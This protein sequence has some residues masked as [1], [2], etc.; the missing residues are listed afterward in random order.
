MKVGEKGKWK[1]YL[2]AILAVLCLFGGNKV[3][4][5]AATSTEECFGIVVLFDSEGEALDASTAVV[6][7]VN[8]T[9][10]V[11][12]K[13]MDS[14]IEG[15]V[16]ILS[17]GTGNTYLLE[18]GGTDSLGDQ[19]LAL[20]GLDASGEGYENAGS[21]AA[22]LEVANP[23]QNEIAVAVYLGSESGE[24]EALA[25][26]LLECDENGILTTDQYPVDA[27]YPAA[28]VNDEGK[29]VGMC[30][31]ENKILAVGGGEEF[32]ANASEE[33]SPT[34]E[35]PSPTPE[36]PSPTP[37]EPSP[38]PEEP[39]PAP[40]A[41]PLPTRESRSSSETGET[42]FVDPVPPI[43]PD[44]HGIN[45]T[46]AVVAAV[47]AVIAVAVVLV[48]VSKKKKHGSAPLQTE[49]PVSGPVIEPTPDTMPVGYPG[50]EE[51]F[52]IPETPKLWLAAKGGCM[53]GR[54]YPVEKNEITIGR[55][56]SSAIRYPA[57]TAGVSR[58][59]AKLYW[60]GG[61]LM[62]MDCNSTSGT[63][64]QRQG[65]LTPMTPVEVRSGDVFY[66]GEKINSF[67]IRD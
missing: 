1:R 21:D 15:S 49:T 45:G 3:L 53:N 33:P 25:M 56:A 60:Q 12:T 47:A 37:E 55:D 54:V 67:I 19:E 41:P 2:A 62:L 18:Y 40:T 38:T 13:V 65:K 24:I 36:E 44:E 61:R 66:I 46:I 30:L 5:R 26:T 39:S 17:T 9:L 31:G 14:T 48:V 16:A 23:H 6:V 29:L 50:A 10:G 34:P 22:F 43:Q 8:G 20:W 28:L 57:D 52:P 59:H 4:A 63:F 32:Y 35:E 27:D 58:V 42:S 64:L 7:N 51:A 11:F